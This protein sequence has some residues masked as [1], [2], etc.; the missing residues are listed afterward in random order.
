MEGPSS[1]SL[2]TALETARPRRLRLQDGVF[3]RSC[4][5]GL[6][7]TARSEKCRTFLQSTNEI[8][9]LQVNRRMTSLRTNITLCDQRTQCM[10]R[11]QAAFLAKQMKGTHDANVRFASARTSLSH[12]KCRSVFLCKS[13]RYSLHLN[14]AAKPKGSFDCCTSADAMLYLAP[15]LK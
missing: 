11:E 6:Q 3:G 5:S 13:L 15:K 9:S 2:L 7:N 10:I 8:S 1:S 12:R 14:S 4:I